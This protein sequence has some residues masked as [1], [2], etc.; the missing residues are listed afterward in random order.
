[1]LHALCVVEALARGAAPAPLRCPAANCGA[2]HPRRDALQAAVQADPGLRNRA[3]RMGGGTKGDEDLRSRG[4]WYG[5]DQNSLGI[6]P[7]LD[8]VSMDD[9]RQRFATGKEVKPELAGAHARLSIHVLGILNHT[10]REH[11]PNRDSVTPNSLVR[12]IKLRYLMPA[13]LHSAGRSDQEATEVGV[14]RER[15]HS[16][17]APVPDGVHQG[18]GL[19]AKGCCP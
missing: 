19:Q 6:G 10:M 5:W 13:L 11:R 2:Q 3:Q 1:M 9:V 14:G 15:G 8:A 12:A 7:P 17:S 18:R 4:L 16:A